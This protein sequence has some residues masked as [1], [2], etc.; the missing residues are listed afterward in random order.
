MLAVAGDLCRRAFKVVY[1]WF[2]LGGAGR[3]SFVWLS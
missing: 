1:D 2:R 3:L